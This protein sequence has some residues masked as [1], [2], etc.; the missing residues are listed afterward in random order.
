MLAPIPSTPMSCSPPYRS[1]CTRQ[2]HRT[3][4]LFGD[5]QRVRLFGRLRDLHAAGG[6][7]HR[8]DDVVIAGAA[9]DIAFE[10]VPDGGFVELA[11]GSLRMMAMH[12][13]DRR[14]DHARG[15]IAALQAVIVA[16]RR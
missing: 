14:H 7:E 8:L 16:E 2:F 5:G 13:I 10:L 1:L 4:V 3:A 9:A 11:A 12:D 6:V 15:V